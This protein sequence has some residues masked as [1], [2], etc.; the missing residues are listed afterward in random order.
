MR[1]ASEG[2]RFIR[3]ATRRSRDELVERRSTAS[4]DEPAVGRR[5]GRRLDRSVFRFPRLSLG[6]SA[7]DLNQ[8]R[9]MTTNTRPLEFCERCVGI[10]DS[11]DQSVAARRENRST[12]AVVASVCLESRFPVG[13]LWL[14]AHFRTSM[15]L[16][17]AKRQPK[18]HIAR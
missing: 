16:C 8:S 11:V 17:H 12:V 15:V 9:R 4:R 2:P 1:K 5:A 14:V 10:T 3:L 6:P 13:V 7:V 18:S